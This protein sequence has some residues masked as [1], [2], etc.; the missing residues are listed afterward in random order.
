MADS[1]VKVPNGEKPYDPEDTVD[2]STL[3]VDISLP[4]DA[5]HSPQKG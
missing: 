3:T 1:A 5:V 2:L 4:V